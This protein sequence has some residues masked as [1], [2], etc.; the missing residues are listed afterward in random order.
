MS[1]NAPLVPGGG[2]QVTVIGA[3]KPRRKFRIGCFGWSFI[4]IVLILLFGNYHIDGLTINNQ[5]FTYHGRGIGLIMKLVGFKN[6]LAARSPQLPTVAPIQSADLTPLPTA[7]PT[8]EADPTAETNPASTALPAQQPTTT[9]AEAKTVT[10]DGV[11]AIGL[12]VQNVLANVHIEPYDGETIIVTVKGYDFDTQYITR[13]MDGDRL[14]V[15]GTYPPYDNDNNYSSSGNITMINN[16]RIEN[17]GD[18]TYTVNN[19]IHRLSEILIQVPNGIWTITGT[20]AGDIDVGNTNGWT[21]VNVVGGNKASVGTVTELFVNSSGG[22]TTEVESCSTATLQVS[23]GGQ[24]TITNS[25]NVTIVASGESKTTIEHFNGDTVNN[26]SHGGSQLHIKE[27]N[28][29]TLV[30]RA[31]GGSFTEFLG[32]VT[33]GYFSQSG[34]S[35][36]HVTHVVNVLQERLTGGSRLII[37]RRDN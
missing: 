11:V 30:V 8:I 16:I 21:T 27:G 6:P 25:G 28:A 10:D 22:S 37:N 18:G 19:E 1:A 32:T 4:I 5:R 12:I 20:L 23:G 26:D 3:P 36:T 35:T 17:N 15:E 34:G 9:T 2:P 14:V 29:T 31:S 13:R 7:E 24:T 33:N